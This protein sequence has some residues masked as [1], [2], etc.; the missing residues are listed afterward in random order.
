M[1]RGDHVAHGWTVD[2]RHIGN[3]DGKLRMGRIPGVRRNDVGGRGSKFPRGD[4]ATHTR[5]WGDPMPC[6]LA[7]M[8][9]V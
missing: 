8:G 3:I 7:S 5:R 9:S 4:R 6:V 1:V 2:A